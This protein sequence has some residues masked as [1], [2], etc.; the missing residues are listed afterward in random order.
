MENA[1]L[2][3]IA[4]VDD[5]ALLRQAM[6]LRLTLLGY[7][8]VL[9]AENGKEFLDQ[10]PKLPAAPDACLLDIN[11]P[12]MDGFETAALL[13]KDWPQMKIIFF[14]MHNSRAF[15]SKAKQLGAHGFLTKDATVD[16]LK[17]T[18]FIALEGR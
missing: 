13:K 6:S 8:V 9:E 14:T 5:H 12:V 4:I 11:M 17:K 2:N 10:L 7:K 3:T 18:L 15:M 16:E 1:P